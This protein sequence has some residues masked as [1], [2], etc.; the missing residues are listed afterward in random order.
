MILGSATGFTNKTIQNIL[1]VRGRP[2]PLEQAGIRIPRRKPSL[3]P[4]YI[5]I[6]HAALALLD[7]YGPSQALSNRPVLF[8][9]IHGFGIARASCRLVIHS[10]TREAMPTVDASLL[11]PLLSVSTSLL[12]PFGN[13]GSSAAM[14]YTLCALM[15]V[16]DHA[17]YC[18]LAIQDICEGRNIY[19]FSLK[20]GKARV[21]DEGFYIAG[22]SP[23][24]VPDAVKRW[25][26]WK[27]EPKNREAFKAL[28]GVE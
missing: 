23:T 15:A 7:L 9:L 19:T 22:T 20:S 18:T 5:F 6:G 12:W 11:A 27:N 3:Q 4:Y 8:M 10:M 17:L 28:Y 24:G 26:S 16:G 25:Q 13:D 21:I 1:I 14:L 2:T